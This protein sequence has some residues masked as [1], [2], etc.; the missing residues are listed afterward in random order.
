MTPVLLATHSYSV[1]G[2]GQAPAFLIAYGAV[3][4]H[5]AC[6]VKRSASLLEARGKYPIAMKIMD[7]ESLRF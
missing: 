5:E 6:E 2:L 4:A 7:H 3:F 1:L